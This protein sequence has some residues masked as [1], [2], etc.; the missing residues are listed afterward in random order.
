MTPQALIVVVADERPL[1]DAL[2]ADLERRFG[3]DYQVSGEASDG[4]SLRLAQYAAHRQDVAVVIAAAQLPAGGVTG[5]ELLAGVRALHPLARRILLVERGQ[6]R[7][8]P[9]QQAMVLGQADSYLFVPWAPREPWLYLPM[10]E[11]LADWSRARPTPDIAITLIGDTGQR[12]HELRDMFSRA[13]IPFAFHDH[14]SKSGRAELARLHRSGDRRP[15]VAFFSGQLLEN[16]SDADVVAALGFSSDPEDRSCD[17]AVLGAGPSGLSAAVYATSEGLSTTVIDPGVPGGQ[18][19]TSSMIRN[20]LGFSRGVSGADLT[21]RAVEQAWLFGT[22]MLLAQRAVSI[23]ADGDW[24]VVVTAD[25]GRFRARAVIVAIGVTWRRLQVPSLEKLLGTGVFYGAAGS[26]ADA[27]AGRQVVVVGGGNSAGQAAIHL[28]RRAAG[29]TVVVRRR[30]LRET[31]SRYLIA[32]I[33]AASNITVRP[34]SEVVQGLGAGQLEAVVL[35]N[36]ASGHTESV[37]AAAL[38]A[39]IGAEPQTGWLKDAVAQDDGGYILTG[40][41]IPA[42][43]WALTRS[44]LFAE[45]SLPGVF[46]VGDVQHGST[47]RVA[48][49][50]GSGA[51]AVQQV[52]QYLAGLPGAS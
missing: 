15:V 36:R 4:A 25:G 45:T 24:R 29:V 41:D 50:V 7:G 14:E 2:V 12:S 51:V 52:H 27:M 1:R 19:G 28:A 26:E 35:R 5:T 3:A 34:G 37:P 46:A 21:N 18:A 49:S 44:P 40:P 39:M 8:H 23:S 17:V 32:E 48:T 10:S 38:F 13:S 31:M 47:K 33:E 20:Y 16:P 30:S 9:V 22:D 42:G 43:A 6:W 11:A